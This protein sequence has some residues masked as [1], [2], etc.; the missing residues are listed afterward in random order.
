MSTLTRIG[1]VAGTEFRISLRNRWVLLATVILTL[2]ALALSFP[3]A[4]G[5]SL[6]A[7]VLTLAA[8]SLSTLSVYLIPLI[9]LLVSYD[10]FAGEIERGT[11]AIVLATP[12]RRGELLL[13]KFLG[14]ASVVSI[15]VIVG[16]GFAAGA[17]VSI[18]GFDL[19]GLSAWVRLSLTAIALGAVFVSAGMAISAAVPRSG[20]AAAL[21]VGVWLLAVVL[22][23]LALL[24]GLVADDGGFFTKSLFPFFV[25]ANPGDAFRI[26]NLAALQ[27]AAPVSGLDGLANTLPFS[28]T[29]ALAS[30][31]FWLVAMLAG[32]LI[33]TRRLT[34]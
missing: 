13:G 21:A 11:M 4:G 3:G 6:K 25:I 29:Y 31:F 26:F 30:L 15:A 34:P 5:A 23:D 28:P 17:V 27:T 2:F 24:A 16:Y 12:V 8:A 10:S 33:S 32:G 14:L 19:V 18:Y 7:G 22:Y 1:A 9:A 20:T